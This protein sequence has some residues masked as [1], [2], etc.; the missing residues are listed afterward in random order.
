MLHTVS[1]IRGA[2][3]SVRDL[4]VGFG[5]IWSTRIFPRIS[6]S[7]GRRRGPLDRRAGPDRRGRG[8]ARADGPVDGVAANLS[9]LNPGEE[10]HARRHRLHRARRAGAADDARPQRQRLLRHRSSAHCSMRR[11]P[12]L[13]RRGRRAERRSAPR[14]RSDD[15]RLAVVRR[16]DGAGLLRRE[17]DPSADDGAGG[18]AADSDL[19]PQHVRAGETGHG[20]L[21]EPHVAC[22]RSR[23]SPASTGW[24]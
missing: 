15:D 10:R 1:V 18:R 24:R 11:D 7:G 20:D 12:H 2:P 19:D 22:T 16:G 8:A 14:A 21:R 4:I 3:A 13:D 17:G 6:R 5:E 9:R 23:G